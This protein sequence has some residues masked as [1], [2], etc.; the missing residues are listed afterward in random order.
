MVFFGIKINTDEIPK[1][2]SI[3]KHKCFFMVKLINKRLYLLQLITEV[4]K[5]EKLLLMIDCLSL[6]IENINVDKM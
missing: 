5:S 2:C 1:S 4:I 3:K 6:Y